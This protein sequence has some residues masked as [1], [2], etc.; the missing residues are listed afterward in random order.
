MMDD[1]KR[2]G[3]HQAALLSAKRFDEK[4]IYLNWINLLNS[5]T[6]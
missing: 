4:T 5:L 6:N 2:I 3:Y 1:E